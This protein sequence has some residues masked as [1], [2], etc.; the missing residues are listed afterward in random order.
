VKCVLASALAAA[1]APENTGK[2]W[3]F[4]V[5]ESSGPYKFYFP[6]N[7]RIPQARDVLPGSGSSRSLL[8]IADEVGFCLVPKRMAIFD[9]V[10]VSF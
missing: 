10:V 6:R 4:S 1:I 7:K 8:R 5:D 3:S 2:I 9:S